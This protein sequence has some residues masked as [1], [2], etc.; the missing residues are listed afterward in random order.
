MNILIKSLK[1]GVEYAAIYNESTHEVEYIKGYEDYVDIWPSSFNNDGTYI[2]AHTH[3]GEGTF[4]P[5]DLD[6]F[7]IQDKI[8]CMIVI[9]TNKFS[10][11]III[12][13]PFTII[14]KRSICKNI[15]NHLYKCNQNLEQTILDYSKKYNFIYKQN[16]KLDNTLK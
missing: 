5:Q 4:S 9:Q 11:D 6:Y 13:T 10:Y 8:R 14:P 7:F 16:I 3:I 2:L 1:L 15:I 12:K